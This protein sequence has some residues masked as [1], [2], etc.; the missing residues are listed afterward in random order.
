MKKF[1]PALVLFL[2]TCQVG[3]TQEN[4]FSKPNYQSIK[5]K[6]SSQTSGFHYPELFERYQEHDTTLQHEHYRMLY[7]GYV[8]QP[9]YAPGESSLFS[10]SLRM[11]YEKDNLRESDFQKIIR[12]ER[13]V[14]EKDPFSLR[15]LNAL[16]YAHD[17]AGNK[18]QTKKLDYKINLIVETILSSGDGLQEKSAWHVNEVSHEYDILNVLGFEPKS[19]QSLRRE[20]HDYIKVKD[21]KYGIGGFYFN[22]SQIL[23][24]KKDK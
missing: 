15:D 7:Y 4:N 13:R 8:F 9:E 21:N 5:E 19:D 2:I 14:L 23:D 18:E 16:A 12:Y 3:F 20:G 11:I 1:L 17:Q 6:T 22:I 10:D 24:H